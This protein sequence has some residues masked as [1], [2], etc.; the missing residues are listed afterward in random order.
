[1]KTKS[2]IAGLAISMAFM[3]SGMAENLTTMGDIPAEAMSH[4]EMDK[5]EGK[6]CGLLG[7]SGPGY[8]VLDGRPLN[9]NNTS[10]NRSASNQVSGN[11]AGY[12]SGSALINWSVNQ[13]LLKYGSGNN[14][15]VQRINPNTANSW[16]SRITPYYGRLNSRSGFK[17]F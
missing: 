3:S 8:S 7:C 6:G 10:S 17:P 12:S 16:L 15:N 5:I 11:A 1:M 14:S 4:G 2:L 9:R 13:T